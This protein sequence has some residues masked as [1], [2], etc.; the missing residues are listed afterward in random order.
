MPPPACSPAPMGSR[1]GIPD[2][3]NR[4]VW[5]TPYYGTFGIPT[6]PANVPLPPIGVY[7]PGFGP[8]MPPALYGW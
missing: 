4:Y 3:P 7:A 6:A 2:L 5:R 1:S 8:G